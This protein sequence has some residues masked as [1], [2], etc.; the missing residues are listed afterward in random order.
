MK[1]HN[2]P[3][4]AHDEAARSAT[5]EVLRQ[6]TTSAPTKPFT[7]TAVGDLIYLRPM[8]PTLRARVPQMLELLGGADVVYGNLE[9]NVFDL[10]SADEPEEIVPEAA[11]GGTWMH[12]SSAI[13]PELV[14]F[15]FNV[16]AGANNHAGDWGRGGMRSTIRHMARHELSLAGVGDTLAQATLPKYTDLAFGRVG[17]VSA[18]TTYTPH[19][20][21]ADPSG[22]APARAGVNAIHLTPVTSLTPAAFADMENLC[23][24]VGAMAG[25]VI[26]PGSEVEWQGSR[27]VAGDTDRLGL[28]YRIDED[29]LRR[30]LTAIRQARQNSNF[31]IFSVHSH[32]PYNESQEPSDALVEIA[33]RAVGAG[34]GLVLCHGPHQLRGIEI[35][36]GV[37]IVYSLGNFFMM[38]NSLDIVP[39]DFSK[40]ISERYSI[41]NIGRLTVPEQF[42]T[43]NRN[44]FAK[45]EMLESAI[46]RF[47]F[48]EGGRLKDIRAYPIELGLNH[49]GADIGVPAPASSHVAERILLRLRDLSKEFGTEFTIQTDEA[50]PHAAHIADTN[51]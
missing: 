5:P 27:Y 30:N 48:S 14:A 40:E 28:S 11:S 12:A 13:A 24:K 25:R 39:P 19:S 33:R 10:G 3:T 42:A 46:F 9:T 50:W 4:A 37:P 21:A 7:L 49:T 44:L 34:A 36:E 51:R 22:V 35:F 47:S 43:R 31:V 32:E 18:T 20:R 6:A 38:N 26:E 45:P 2:V 8:L 16:L 1:T 15:G 23:A 17:H 41:D 29:H